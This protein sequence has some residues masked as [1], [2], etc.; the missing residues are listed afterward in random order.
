MHRKAALSLLVSGLALFPLAAIAGWALFVEGAPAPPLAAA[1]TACVPSSFGFYRSAS[2]R[3]AFQASSTKCWT[4]PSSP[5]EVDQ[6]Y[7][8]T[9]WEFG[10]R[11]GGHW[12]RFHL[13][14]GFISIYGWRRVFSSVG[15]NS[16]AAILMEMYLNIGF[17][18]L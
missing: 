2:A 10:G 5:D 1:T 7:A 12:S 17:V 4:T 6:W 13:D 14:L 18:P 16:G 9:G 8:K 11:V 3:I 15:A